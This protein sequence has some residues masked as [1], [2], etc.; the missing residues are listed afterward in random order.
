MQDIRDETQAPANDS[1][2]SGTGGAAGLAAHLRKPS[3]S[4]RMNRFNWFG[5]KREAPAQVDSEL[6]VDMRGQLAAIDKV[7]AVIEFSLDGKILRANDNFLGALGYTL[8]EGAEKV[9]VGSKP[10]TTRS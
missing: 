2:I 1:E 3:E 4:T 8:A 6:T 5:G 10:R 9:V 7:M